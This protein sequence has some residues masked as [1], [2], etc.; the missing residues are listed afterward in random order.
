MLE[1]NQP[2]V[3]T[4][5]DAARARRDVTVKVTFLEGK[6]DP[7]IPNPAWCLITE[8]VELVSFQMVGM[9]PL[10]ALVSST[11]VVTSR[12]AP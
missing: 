11:L 9:M 7:T 10:Q 12:E 8:C 1:S 5:A 4:V 3:Y 2:C 6:R